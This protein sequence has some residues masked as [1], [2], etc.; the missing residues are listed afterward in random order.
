MDTRSD[1]R[2]LE[3][4]LESYGAVVRWQPLAG[5]YGYLQPEL[6]PTTPP[7]GLDNIRITGY[8]V[9]APPRQLAKDRVVQTVTIEYVRVDT[10]RLYTLVDSQLWIRAANGDCERANP[11]PE[12]K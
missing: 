8:E 1:A 11:I 12:F 2:R 9:T 7:P 5:V 3:T 6:Q 4:T 10:Q